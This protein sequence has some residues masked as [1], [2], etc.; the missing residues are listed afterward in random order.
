[1]NAVDDA[2]GPN[3]YHPHAGSYAVGTR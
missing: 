2:E 3:G 1:M